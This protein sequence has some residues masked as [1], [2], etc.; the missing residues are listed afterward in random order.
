MKRLIILAV[1]AVLCAAVAFAQ[2]PHSARVY[3]NSSTSLASLYSGT[4]KTDR[5]S[6]RILPGGSSVVDSIRLPYTLAGI[7]VGLSYAADSGTDT[8]LT[9][10]VRDITD[11]LLSTPVSAVTGDSLMLTA[12]KNSSTY[13]S[14]RMAITRTAVSR[15][16]QITTSNANVAADSA[17]ALRVYADIWWW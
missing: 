2:A 4:N 14:G 6:V 11:S 3:L 17:S 10:C 12:Q 16:L 1:G 8:A 15:W 9:M 7:S 13:H 5:D